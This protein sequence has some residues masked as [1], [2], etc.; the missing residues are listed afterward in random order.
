[1]KIL[2]TARL[3]LRTLETS[4]A[5][6]FL[7]MINDP[8][9]IENIGDKGIRT[10]AEAEKNIEQGPV[11]MQRRLGYSLYLVER[12]S[13]GVPVGLCGLIKRDALPDAD[14]G[15]AI[16]PEYWGEGYAYEAAAA[17]VL[18]ARDSIGLVRLLGITSPQNLRS[19][20]LLKKLGL[21]FV[22]VVRFKDD[23]SD[24]NLYSLEFPSRH[25]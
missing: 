8:S 17:V 1:M 21:S 24:T 2:A 10:V 9:W 4:D 20:N 12:S 23:G 13:D 16:W 15:Y 11:L 22:R 14:I 3:T 19:N 25:A 7:Q 6:F 5:P 18:H